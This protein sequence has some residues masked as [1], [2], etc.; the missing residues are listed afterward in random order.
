VRDVLTSRYFLGI[1]LVLGSYEVI[2]AVNDFTFHKGVELTFRH[3][4]SIPSLLGLLAAALD[5]ATGL[6]ARSWLASAVGLETSAPSLGTFFSQF[7]LTMNIAAL[8]LQLLAASLVIRRAGMTAALLLLPLSLAVFSAGFLQAPAL[9]LLQ[10]L[11]L[12]DNSL[13]Y[14]VNQT[15]REMLFVPIPR[16]QKYRTLSF[17]EMFVQRAAKAGGGFLLLL[18][19]LVARLT[20]LASLR[21]LM[22]LTLPVALLWITIA[23]F[24]GRRYHARCREVQHH[25]P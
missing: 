18:F 14:S 22:L 24:L 15:A 21:W 6:G 19:P 11:Y 23:I 4:G 2:S 10:L 20:D 7:F 12:A 5:A 16:E 3:D 9:L 25:A 17:I 1:C 13:N 8:L